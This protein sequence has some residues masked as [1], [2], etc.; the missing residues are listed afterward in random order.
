[1][2]KPGDWECPSCGTNCFASKSV[3]FRCG[4]AKPAPGGAKPKGKNGS[5]NGHQNAPPPAGQGGG[6]GSGAAAGAGER[7]TIG[8]IKKRYA[9]FSDHVHQSL[10]VV[11]ESVINYEAI[12]SLLEYITYNFEEGAI[13]VFL[14]GLA[15]IT[16]ML[17]ALAGNPLFNDEEKTRVYP[18]HGSLSTTDQKAIFEVP[19]KGVR[20][21]VV[22]TNIAETSITIEDCVFVVDS[23]RVK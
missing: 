8:E 4:A 19:P 9:R 13:L 20:K 1:G 12:S 2:T 22:S 17:E 21:I 15:E 3:C 7:P 14:P 18:L 11:D 10:L 6:S 5:R 23:C 16:K